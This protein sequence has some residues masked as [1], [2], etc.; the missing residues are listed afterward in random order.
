MNIVEAVEFPSTGRRSQRTHT[1]KPI[2][3]SWTSLCLTSVRMF[4]SKIAKNQR[5]M[6]YFLSSLEEVQ[7]Y[8]LMAE[9]P[10]YAILWRYTERYLCSRRSKLISAEP[11]IRRHFRCCSCFPCFYYYDS[12]II[13]LLNS[14]LL[15]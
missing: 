15:Y 8:V 6:L 1:A 13:T 2:D 11:S 5:N 12:N 4:F 14:V 10:I 3:S 9:N 7:S